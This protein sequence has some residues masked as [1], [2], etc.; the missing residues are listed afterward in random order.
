MTAPSV[1]R[2]AAITGEAV[3]SAVTPASANTVPTASAC[4]QYALLKMIPGLNRYD[5]ESRSAQDDLTRRASTKIS[6]AMTMSEIAA[7][8]L[9]AKRKA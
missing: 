3:P 8:N 4:P 6:H 9:S 2:T 7:G 5:A 1:I